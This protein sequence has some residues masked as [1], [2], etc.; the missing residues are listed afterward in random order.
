[1]L[2]VSHGVTLVTHLVVRGRAPSRSLPNASV[3]V[4]RSSTDGDVVDRVGW[5]P[6][7]RAVPGVEL[8]PR[9]ATN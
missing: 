3:T 6:S 5:D 1:V 9:D 4:L 8:A 2:I 7:G